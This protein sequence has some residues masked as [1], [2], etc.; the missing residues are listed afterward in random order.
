MSHTEYFLKIDTMSSLGSCLQ[1]TPEA[2]Q[3][4]LKCLLLFPS[5]VT[6]GKMS[7]LICTLEIMKVPPSQGC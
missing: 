7:Y 2:R 5:W 6:R 4:G 1:V 3:P